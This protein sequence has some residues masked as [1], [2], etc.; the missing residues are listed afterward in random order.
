[1]ATAT[2]AAV[3]TSAQTSPVHSLAGEWIGVAA[4]R[5]D[6]G[7]PVSIRLSVAAQRA[8]S[9]FL[10]VTIP[11]SR[12][13]ALAV[14]SPYSDQVVGRLLGDSLHV[15]FTAD[16][17]LGFIGGLVPP[18]SE[19]I[20]L[21][22][23][24]RDDA[25]VGTV[26][27]TRYSSPIILRRVHHDGSGGERP[28]TFTSRLDS[29]RLGGTLLLPNG[30]GPFPAAVFV[31]G[32]DPD[33]R[34]AWQLEAR[35]LRERGIAA[36]VYDKRGV[37][38]SKGASHDL[39]SWDDLTGDVEGAVAF[40]RGLPEINPAR[41]GLI[42]QSQ[43]TWVITKVAARDRAVSFVVLI[44]GGGMSAA[45]QETYRTGAMMRRDGFAP[46]EIA[47]AVDF[48]RRKFAVAQSGIGWDS[49]D[50]TMQRL[51][52]DSVRWFPG[53]GTGAATQSLAVLR[54]YGVLQFNYDPRPDLARIQAPVLVIMGADDVV[55]PPDTVIERVR[56]G[57]A[58]GNRRNPDAKI[59][60]RTT[61]GMMVLQTIGGAPFRRVI[62]ADFVR[63][64]VEWVAHQGN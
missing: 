19:R 4:R 60:P 20:V 52:S 32:S 2:L 53:Y 51:R 46:A 31:T 10:D 49:L 34:E 18:D 45:E 8:D 14:P 22:G 36:L 43:G 29:L 16:I 33:T 26:I 11:E 28:V 7:Q 50:S 40:L 42:G 58:R 13:I 23:R 62:S 1:M 47:R 57:L 5:P 12:Q 25:L 61:H 44:S 56:N 35:A 3:Q 9:L 15:E 63:A 39:A 38:E 21:A 59:L 24:F 17:G 37:G 55:F 6:A 54:L 48:Q 30:R 64:L 41:V 27:I